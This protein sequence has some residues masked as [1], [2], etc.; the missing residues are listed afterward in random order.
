[1][2][3]RVVLKLSGEALA[4][5]SEQLCFNTLKELAFQLK[6]VNDL[7]IQ[8][9]VMLGGG[10]I[11]R[12]RSS[13]EMERTQADHM[14]MLATAINALALQ[15]TLLKQGTPCTILSA[16][17]MERLFETFTARRAE[18]LFEKGHCLI[19]AC[20]SGLPFFSTDTAAALRAAELGAEA[21][22]LAKNVD[23]I[24]SADPNLDPLATRYEKL[25]YSEVL[26]KNLTAIDQT[27]VVLCKEQ[28]IP[29]IVF[30]L[31]EKLSI[32]RAVKGEL[33]GTR[34]T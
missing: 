15:D 25:T 19:F 11:W 1:M 14:G 27:A 16:I 13:G 17:E 10:N 26:E 4:L 20:G 6:Q 34:I 28:R 33:A 24:Y 8:A 30:G 32:L 22:L 21:L 29:I 9:G 23:A 12:G 2:Y 18:E 31:N 3:T 5:G 7:G